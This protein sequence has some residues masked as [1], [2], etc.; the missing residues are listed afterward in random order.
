MI[1]VVASLAVVAGAALAALG[2][3]G[4]LRFPDAFTRMHAASVSETLG[5]GLL[6]LGMVLQA[7]FTLVAVKLLIIFFM[8]MIVA[9]VSTH[10][11]ARAALHAG[12]LPLLVNA[13]D[14]LVETDIVT[15]FPELGSRLRQPLSSEQ[16]NLEG[17]AATGAL[18][19][20]PEGGFA[21]ALEGDGSAAGGDGEDRR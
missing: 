2:G 16:V 21:Y 17:E 13:K 12:R 3:L 6:V 19:A 11:L 8:L 9:P 5:L 14:W 15:L 4:L 20:L 10:A 18:P 1:D 7:G